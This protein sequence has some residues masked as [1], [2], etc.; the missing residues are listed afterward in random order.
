[1]V[2]LEFAKTILQWDDMAKK[3]IFRVDI[4]IKNLHKLLS[5]YFNL[6]STESHY[7]KKK[8]SNF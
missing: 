3:Q 5:Q 1:M 6:V 2:E 8:V 4:Q 7:L